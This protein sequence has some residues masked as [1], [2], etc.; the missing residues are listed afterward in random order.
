[1]NK[2]FDWINWVGLGQKAGNKK[3]NEIPVITELLRKIQIKGQ[4]I[5]R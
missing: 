1:M 4:V 5:T 2:L 3:S